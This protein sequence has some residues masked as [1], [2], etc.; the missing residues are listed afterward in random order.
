MRPAACPFHRRAPEGVF[1]EYPPWC[2]PRPSWFR[3]SQKCLDQI[4]IKIEF[5][6]NINY[7]V[8]IHLNR[9]RAFETTFGIIVFSNHYLRKHARGLNR[10]RSFP[11][12]N[13]LPTILKF[14]NF[15]MNLKRTCLFVGKTIF[16]SHFEETIMILVRNF[17]KKKN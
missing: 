6:K 16:K 5:N 14:I 10:T 11:K 3:R 4:I 12:R 9:N 13:A 7:D 2:Y 15:F 17:V 1:A 8:A